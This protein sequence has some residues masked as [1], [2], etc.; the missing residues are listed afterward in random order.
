MKTLDDLAAEAESPAASPALAAEA[1]RLLAL[2]EGRRWCHARAIESLHRIAFDGSRW[3]GRRIREI[4][5][6]A[7]RGRIV[8]CPQR[9]YCRIDEARPEEIRHCLASLESRARKY[10][11]R[12]Q[13]IWTLLNRP[14]AMQ[15]EFPEDDAARLVH[16]VLL[17]SET[18]AW[19]TAD[20]IRAF[21]SGAGVE[22]PERKVQSVAEESEGWIIGHP[23]RGY[24]H[25][26]RASTE[27]IGAAW[28]RMISRSRSLERRLRETR[29]AAH[30]LLG[31]GK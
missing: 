24:C 15:R 19:Q 13:T 23:A 20:Q 2:L 17:R 29:A 4:V 10:Q 7:G 8:A 18:P 1:D 31:G 25:A 28:R 5:E 14:D 27:E 16:E 21:A 11:R 3:D 12:A 30:G 9:G 22:I 6:R 26:W